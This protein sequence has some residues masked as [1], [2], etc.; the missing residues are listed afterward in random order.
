MPDTGGGYPVGVLVSGDNHLIL[1]GPRPDREHALLLMRHWTVVRIGA[2]TP[3]SLQQ[4]TIST[5]E[6]REN[7]QWAVIVAGDGHRNPSVVQLL[8]ELAARG[9]PIDDY[10][11]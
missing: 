3:P 10:S 4:W 1:R 5:K 6:F 11:R 2:T 7:L 8:A 9:A